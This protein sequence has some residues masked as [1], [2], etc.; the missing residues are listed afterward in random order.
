MT[1]KAMSLRIFFPAAAEVLTDYLPHGEGLIAHDMLSGLARR[2]HRVVACG[3]TLAFR[4]PPPY[5]VAAIGG[6]GT[7]PSLAPIGY[8]SLAAR[9]LRRRGGANSFDVAHWLFPQG[10]HNML[11]ALPRRLPLVVGPLMLSWPAPKP[12]L[13]AGLMVRHLARPVFR[14]LNR[15]A[16]RHARRIL[17][18]LPDA[19]ALVG[20]EDRHRVSVVPF[21]ID[22]TAYMVAPLPSVPTILFIGRLNVH[23][24]VRELLHA[25]AAVRDAGVNA[26]LRFAGEGSEA[27]WL[28]RRAD[29]LGL[30]PSVEL[31]GRVPHNEIKRLVADCSLLC[32]PSDGEP[33]GMAI[34]EAMA[35]GRA[36]I[37]GDRG[38]PRHLV[39]AHGGILVAP[40]DD[41]SLAAALRSLLN[42]PDRLRTMG[43][44]NR[45]RVEREFSLTAVLDAIEHVYLDV[46]HDA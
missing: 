31:L 36:V 45:Q 18:S 43:A 22:E 2:G 33:F 10:E 37:A 14:L 24:G 32:L 46:I 38:G 8:A 5:E 13:S 35:A 42:D 9:E 16:L 4:E 15:R 29:E 3:R 26:R 39:D 21:G 12:P 20:A 1:A 28:Q 17:V 41:R 27:N 23:K 7:L 34:L 11:D 6:G 44:F 25:F 30:E 19:A 40:G